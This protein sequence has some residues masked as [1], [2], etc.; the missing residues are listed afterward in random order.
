MTARG[1][2]SGTVARKASRDV[3]NVNALRPQAASL[4]TAAPANI[5]TCVVTFKF[6]RE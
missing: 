5:L 6:A 2:G 1:A 3:C 4:R